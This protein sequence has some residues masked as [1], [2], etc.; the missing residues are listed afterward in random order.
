MDKAIK[1]STIVAFGMINPNAAKANEKLCASVKMEH[2]I[3]NV[4]ILE[5]KKNKVNINR[6]WSKPNGITCEKPSWK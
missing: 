6:I 1:G 3:S 2:W 4:F 5:L